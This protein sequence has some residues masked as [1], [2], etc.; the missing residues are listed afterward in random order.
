METTKDDLIRRF[1]YHAPDFAA[2]EKHE[3]VN[4]MT[5][6]VALGLL[7]VVPQSRGLSL[8]LTK[9][10]EARMWAN[11]AIAVEGAPEGD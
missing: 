3:A 2:V 6:S 8:A 9:L 7:D 1:T 10:E 5:R 11:Q 4:A